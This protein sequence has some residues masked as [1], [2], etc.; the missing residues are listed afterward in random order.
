MKKLPTCILV[1]CYKKQFS[2]LLDILGPYLH[3]YS[4]ILLYS[5]VLVFSW[6]G[7]TKSTNAP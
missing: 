7:K 2:G 1:W 6:V 4:G 3:I 5:F